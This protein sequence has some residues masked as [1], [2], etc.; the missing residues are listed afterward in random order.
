MTEIDYS[1]INCLQIKITSNAG[2]LKWINIENVHDL[3]KERTFS[4]LIEML[5]RAFYEERKKP[6]KKKGVIEISSIGGGN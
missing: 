2:I 4:T 3:D 5:T 6:R 1:K